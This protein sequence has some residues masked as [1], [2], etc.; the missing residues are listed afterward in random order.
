[1]ATQWLW[2]IFLRSAVVRLRSGYVLCTLLGEP[3]LTWGPHIC[4]SLV[5]KQFQLT[6]WFHVVTQWLW[7][8]FLRTGFVRLCS[9]YVL[10][11]VMG[12]IHIYVGPT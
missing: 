1:M 5:I 9:G 4:F 7:V 10:F 2:V 6:Q 8:L 3:L 12:G 11:T